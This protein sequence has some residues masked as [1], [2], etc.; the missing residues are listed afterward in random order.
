[1]AD[2]VSERDKKYLDKLRNEILPALP[3]FCNDFFVG[4]SSVATVLTR[5][6]YARDLALFFKFLTEDGRVFPGKKPAE[7]GLTELESLKNTHIERFIDYVSGYYGDDGEYHTNSDKA[8]ARKLSS[9]RCLFRYLY[10]HD[11]I[12]EN[13]ASKVSAPKIREK[14]IV[15]LEDD[16]VGNVFSLLNDAEAFDCDR[17]NAYNNNNTKARDAALIALLLGTG[18]RVSEAVGL[19]VND[20]NFENKSFLVT[21]KGEKRSI[22][23]LNDEIIEKLRVYLKFRRHRLER[24]KIDPKSV[25]ALFLSLQNKRIGV[26]AVEMIVK[27]YAAIA[28]PLKK[29]SPHKLR[30]TYGT[31]LYRGTGDI[32]VVAEVLGHADINTTKKHYAAIGEDIKKKAADKVN[33]LRD[34]ENNEKAEDPTE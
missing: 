25:D 10:N 27:K 9:I 4:I 28:S 18:I 24:K 31:A 7:L 20:L 6:G 23:Y 33:F 19:N 2:F 3:S 15:R 8:K 26:R 13:V 11:M 14:E 32:Y 34:A 22:L 5:Y 12:K 21:R 30:A 29:I 17:Q 1:M 16:E